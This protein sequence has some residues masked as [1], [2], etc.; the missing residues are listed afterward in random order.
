VHPTNSLCFQA[1]VHPAPRGV[2]AMKN[3]IMDVFWYDITELANL[4]LHL[5]WT[6]PK[7]RRWRPSSAVRSAASSTRV[8][9]RD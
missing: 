1:C 7:R 8:V 2:K 4:N 9:S 5:G 3:R 6:R